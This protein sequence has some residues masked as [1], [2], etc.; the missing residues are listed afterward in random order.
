[1]P[2][3]DPQK[4]E[5]TFGYAYQFDSSEYA[6]FLRKFAETNGVTR[7]EGR[8]T[9]SEQDKS[10]GHISSVTLDSGQSVTTDLF[11]D[12]SGF[13]GLLIEQAYEAG[14]DDWSQWLPCNRAIAVPSEAV[15]DWPDSSVTDKI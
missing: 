12:C 7:I 13:R 5:S 14:Y 8:I 2:Y 15:T 4:I 3:L 6:K 1:M 9:H 11:I 10:T